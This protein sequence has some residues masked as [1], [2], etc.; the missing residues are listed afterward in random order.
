LKRVVIPLCRS[1][2]ATKFQ[3]RLGVTACY[4]GAPDSE[5][6]LGHI[7]MLGKPDKNILRAGAPWFAPGL[8]LDYMARHALD[9]WLTSEDLPH[10]ENRVTVGRDGAIHLSKTYYNAE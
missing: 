7:Q 3:R 6:P 2:S 5:L 10:P 1:E 4:W 8:A 9:F